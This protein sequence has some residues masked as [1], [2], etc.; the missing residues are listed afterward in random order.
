MAYDC[1]VSQY[2]ISKW[3]KQVIKATD[4]SLMQAIIADSQ[5][6]GISISNIIMLGF[7]S[8]LT[9]QGEDSSIILFGVRV[10]NEDAGCECKVALNT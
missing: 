4:Q 7:Y 6:T 2:C 8:L 3:S 1:P 10:C 9:K 5:S